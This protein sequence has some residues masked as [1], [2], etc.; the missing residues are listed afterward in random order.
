VRLTLSR[1]AYNLGNLVATASVAQANREPVADKSVATV[2][3]DRRATVKHARYYW[4]LL[5]EEHLN[6]RR[7]E[8]EPDRT[9]TDSHA[10]ERAV[11]SAAECVYQERGRR[12]V[13]KVVW[14]IRYFGHGGADR[15]PLGRPRLKSPFKQRAR[16]PNGSAMLPVFEVKKEISAYN[17][18]VHSVWRRKG[19][20]YLLSKV[21]GGEAKKKEMVKS[22]AFGPRG[23]ALVRRFT[24]ALKRARTC[25]YEDVTYARHPLISGRDLQGHFTFSSGAQCVNAARTASLIMNSFR[26]CEEH[27]PFIH[28]APGADIWGPLINHNHQEI[29]SLIRNG[30]ATRVVQYLTDAPNT[31]YP[32]GIIDS[33]EGTSLI[34]RDPHERDR[35]QV[36]IASTLV[37]LAE[38]IGIIELNSPWTTP[39]AN[40]YL[41]CLP[42]LF[43]R[44]EGRLAIRLHLPATFNG[45]Y[46][47]ETHQGIFTAEMGRALL[48]AILIRD[49]CELL[50]FPLGE[51]KISE[52]GGG[53]AMLAYFCYLLGARHYAIYDL[54]TTNIL[55]NYFL[56][57]GLP[58]APVITFA[59]CGE[60][61]PDG[62]YVLPYWKMDQQASCHL[63][64]NE[65]SMPEIEHRIALDYVSSIKKSSRYFLS[66]NQES[67]VRCA[68]GHVQASVGSLIRESGGFDR[69]LRNL[70]WSLPGYAVELFRVRG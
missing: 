35:A 11:E 64:V 40:I 17:H 42:D 22:A 20:C 5:A 19:V 62:V 53:A 61:K 57:N 6:R 13:A 69:V 48:S 34:R 9:A 16:G 32:K 59:Q 66:F 1:Q 70:H 67:L 2:G 47:L 28:L 51:A 15:R 45:L 58:D 7:F 30:D 43:S 55:Q 8:I 23:T 14:N 60:R 26:R 44:I 54:P 41:H 52:I 39:N 4:L 24:R 46:G 21:D 49:Y 33:A 25:A 29:I 3:E 38:A 10:I 68:N 31:P 36:R 12:G 27:N 37:A 50:G 18:Q 56:L 65:D 63:F